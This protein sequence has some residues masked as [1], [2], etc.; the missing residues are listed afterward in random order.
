MNLLEQINYYLKYDHITGKFYWKEVASNRISVGDEAGY[1]SKQTGYITIRLCGKLYQAHRLVWFLHYFEFPELLDHV[2][3]DRTDNR[4]DN[5]RIATKSQNNAN[6]KRINPNGYRGV[7]FQKGK[8]KAQ[9]RGH[10]GVFSKIEDAAKAY[11]KKAKEVFGEFARL[12]F[13][14]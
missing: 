1:L 4:I 6:N 11:D 13:K 3:G 9:C 2:N 12:N 14:E 7:T 5:L 8:W 10:I